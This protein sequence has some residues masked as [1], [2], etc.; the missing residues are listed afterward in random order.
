MAG[1]FS[2]F[3]DISV[4]L[5]T[6]PSSI[7]FDDKVK[8][9]LANFTSLFDSE[10]AGSGSFDEAWT[11][12]SD[13]Y[14]EH[15]KD[16]L[17]VNFRKKID[18]ILPKKLQDP[19]KDNPTYVPIAVIVCTDD[20]SSD[21]FGE[22]NEATRSMLVTNDWES[23]PYKSLFILLKLA[24]VH[25]PSRPEPKGNLNIFRGLDTDAAFTV[26]QTFSLG[27]FASFTAARKLALRKK[28][29]IIS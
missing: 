21:F 20:G 26:G 22:F 3:A 19:L 29:Q 27:Y 23:F 2:R 4:D 9:E 24:S 6:T 11:N 16:E 1:R 5:L 7:N 13:R 25:L 14:S 28:V 10:R 15:F 12:A 8:Q 18:E 17:P